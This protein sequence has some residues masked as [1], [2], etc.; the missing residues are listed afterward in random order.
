LKIFIFPWKIL[1]GKTPLNLLFFSI[2]SSNLEK[3]IFGNF[4]GNFE[5]KKHFRNIFWR[6]HFKTRNNLKIYIFPLKILRG[7]K[8]P[9][10]SLFFSI[11]FS[12]LGKLTFGNFSGKFEIKKK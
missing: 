4:A 12:N 3:L 9:L 11:I 10:N 6:E 2:K 1:R 5:I 7:G 8:T